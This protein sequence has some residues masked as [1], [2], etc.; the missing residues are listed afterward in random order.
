MLRQRG[1][2]LR[3]TAIPRPTPV[4]LQF[5]AVQRRPLAHK[6]ERT[7]RQPSNEHRACL[8]RDHRMMLR[9]LGMKMGRL[10]STAARSE[11]QCSNNRYK[12]YENGDRGKVLEISVALDPAAA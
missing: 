2:R 6:L 11:H 5:R 1:D 9:V 3:S 4:R 10:R 8:D 12:P 7:T